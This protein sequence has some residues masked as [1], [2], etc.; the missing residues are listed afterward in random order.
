MMA[1]AQGGCSARGQCKCT[2]KVFL[3]STGGADGDTSST[4]RDTVV[5]IPWP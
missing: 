5:L 3:V 1:E 2:E 4:S